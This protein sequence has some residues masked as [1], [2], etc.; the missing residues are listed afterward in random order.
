MKTPAVGD[1]YVKRAAPD[2]GRIVT[3]TRVWKGDDGHTAVAYEWDDD[4][5][6]QC[7][8]ACPL[9]VFQRTYQVEG[10]ELSARDNVRKW[11]I[12]DNADELLDAYAHELAE[13][14]RKYADDRFD[15]GVHNQWHEGAHDG[16]DEIDPEVS[17]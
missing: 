2:E 10:A 16:A 6:D 15:V 3:V 14:I 7:F 8:N 1:R 13:K 11:M 17:S 4:R 12:A 9:D 5:P